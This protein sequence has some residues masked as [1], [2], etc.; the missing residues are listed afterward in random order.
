M[1]FDELKNFCPTCK[2]K[3]EAIKSHDEM[4]YICYF[5]DKEFSEKGLIEAHLKK[6]GNAKWHQLIIIKDGKEF[7]AGTCFCDK[8]IN[9][10][11]K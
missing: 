3:L 2:S 1:K 9:H 6:E 8:G 5:C 11:K 10:M 7:F 4:Y